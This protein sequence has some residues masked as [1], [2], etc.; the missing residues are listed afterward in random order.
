MDLRQLEAFKLILQTGT[1]STAAR[2]L[3]LTQ[4]A[5]SHQIRSLEEELGEQ[6]LVRARP[7]AYLTAAGQ[8]LLLSAERIFEELNE[9]KS[10]FGKTRAGS[11]IGT[12]RV[13]ATHL[14]ISYIYGDLL[15]R[16]AGRHPDVE[17]IFHA[18]ET[19]E[20]PVQR[21]AQRESDIG[22]T[23]LPVEH[24]KLEALQL[25][26][27][28]QVFIVSPKHPLAPHKST[29]IDELR[30]WPFARFEPGT[31]GR[32][33][34]DSLFIGQGGY[35]S[36]LAESNDVEYI[37]RVIRIGL[38]VALVPVFCVHRELKNG[39]IK[40]LR[41]KSGRVIQDAGLVKRNDV[42]VRAVELFEEECR[43]ARGAKPKMVTLEN[44][45]DPLFGS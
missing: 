30:H 40:A 32:H 3:G 43:N 39:T 17:L 19:T 25:I 1:F 29:S 8:R 9:L 6:L 36:I 2:K 16:F 12:L 33:V 4:S 24:A 23:V 45:G 20:V 27:V 18:T 22:F 34:S 5:L 7:R 13:A 31:G 42:S 10:Q 37:K 14:A 21:V 11:S 28:E 44:A 15:E 38:G 41:L 35:P 26:R